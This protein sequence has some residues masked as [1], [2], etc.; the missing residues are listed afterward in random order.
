MI[1]VYNNAFR[2]L[3]SETKQKHG[4]ELPLHVEQYVVVLLADHINRPNWAPE[5]TFAETW[6]TIKTSKNAKILGDECLFLC[7]VFPSYGQRKGLDLEYYGSIG[8]S[9]YS[10]ASADLNAELFGTLSQHFKMVSKFINLTVCR[11]NWS[12]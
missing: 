10:R 11:G 12:P 1:D 4:Y 6:S 2:E 9:S 7:G 8:S 5:T 3:V